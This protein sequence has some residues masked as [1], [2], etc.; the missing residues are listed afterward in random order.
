MVTM[1][2]NGVTIQVYEGDVDWYKRAGYVVVEESKPAK[3]VTV[4]SIAPPKPSKK[5]KA[6]EVSRGPES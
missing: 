1:Y 4:E 2:S 5:S 3:P 6:D